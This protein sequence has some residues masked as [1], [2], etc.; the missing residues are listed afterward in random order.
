MDRINATSL[1]TFGAV[2]LFTFLTFAADTQATPYTWQGTV[3]NSWSNAGNWS[4]VGRPRNTGDF[5]QINN[6]DSVLMDQSSVAIGF[7]TLGTANTSN[8]TIQNGNT[9]SLGSGSSKINT[10]SALT[11]ESGALLRLNGT[12]LVGGQATLNG[13]GEITNQNI[14]EFNGTSSLSGDTDLANRGGLTLSDSAA[15]A[16]GTITHESL[17][18][19]VMGDTSTMTGGKLINTQ[20][21]VLE[22][23]A[24]IAGG[25]VTNQNTFL[26]SDASSISGGVF[27]NAGTLRRMVDFG[28]STI[29]AIVQNTGDVL[30]DGTL[31]FN[32]T[33]RLSGIGQTT[34]T[35]T[36][37]FDESSTF[38]GRRLLNIGGTLEFRGNSLL[39]GGRATEVSNRG[40]MEVFDNAQLAS[41]RIDHRGSPLRFFDN[42]E[43]SGAGINN[44]AFVEFHDNS[45]LSGGSVTN[46][47]AR[48]THFR[49]NS[50]MTDG[51]IRGGG[52][53][54]FQDSTFMSGGSITNTRT[55]TV[56]GD[57]EISGGG[58]TNSGLF[59]NPSSL[60]LRGNA[61]MSGGQIN[62][63]K[64]DVLRLSNF[65]LV[66]GGEIDNSGT[67]LML[68]D[69]AVTG[70]RI[71]NKTDGRIER[72]DTGAATLGG[73]IENQ[74]VID[75]GSGSFTLTGEVSGAGSYEGLITFNGNFRPGNSPALVTGETMNFGASSAL[76]ME[77]GGLSRG[78]E[79]D[80]INAVDVALDGLLDIALLDLGNSFVPTLGDTFDLII[81][82][83]IT[84]NFSSFSFATLSGGLAF[85][86]NLITAGANMIYQLVVVE[87]QVNS[88][89]PGP[90]AIFMLVIGLVGIRLIRRTPAA[91]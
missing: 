84:G 60:R 77:V 80:A 85:S 63:T 74:G 57:A 73:T 20:T 83:Q 48:Q 46:A 14:L 76:F 55:M 49:D 11:T 10:G 35:G 87:G 23:S 8:L 5:V 6:G 67:I 50:G 40:A 61:L 81:A 78:T 26:L 2:G 25:T 64:D 32:G 88:G 18:S 4:P 1:T 37:A 16:G 12:V 29:G 38:E 70:G 45:R 41:G 9:L 43:L 7:L 69:A 82:T 59:N 86:T 66:S 91:D 75:G 21:V 68:D 22:E 27:N 31:T 72:Q 28:T 19:M 24:D 36:L 65:A 13:D 53:V 17:Q 44:S 39:D 33:G 54:T 89:V 42:S 52:N 47:I 34:N 15:I 56:Q 3:N 62:N 30:N 71:E 90:G 51:S 58:I 79:Y